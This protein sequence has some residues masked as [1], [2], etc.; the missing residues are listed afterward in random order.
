MEAP[1]WE[2]DAGG[3]LN[4][5][6]LS[7]ECVKVWQMIMAPDGKDVKIRF[8]TFTKFGD[9]VLT[10]LPFFFWRYVHI[11][12]GLLCRLIFSITSAVIH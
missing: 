4:I 6:G 5:Y 2:S 11:E 10:L 12:L 7:R 8:H 3:V 9:L 1:H